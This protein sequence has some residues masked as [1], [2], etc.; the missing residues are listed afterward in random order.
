MDNCKEFSDK[1]SV[2][3]IIKRYSNFVSFPIFLNDKRLNVQ[4]ALWSES[5]NSVSEERHIEFYKD[6]TNSYDAP[7]DRIHFTSDVP[8]SVQ[9]LFYIPEYHSE[10]FGM[11]RLDPGVSVYSRKILIK[12]KA[13]EILPD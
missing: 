7:M 8:I 11:S 2:E 9:A 10:K 3:K 6:F 4:T 13:K 1:I 5:P 12:A